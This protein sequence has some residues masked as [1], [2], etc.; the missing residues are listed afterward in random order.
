MKRSKKANIVPIQIMINKSHRNS[1]EKFY[2]QWNEW[3]THFEGYE[4][5][6]IFIWI[7]EN[8]NECKFIDAQ[9]RETR[10]CSITIPSHLCIT[11]TMQDV[12]RDLGLVLSRCHSRKCGFTHVDGGDADSTRDVLVAAETMAEVSSEAVV[13]EAIMKGASRKKRRNKMW[14]SVA[15]QAM[16]RCSTCLTQISA[17]DTLDIHQC[18]F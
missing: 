8:H 17:T 11:V 9:S 15:E 5:Q 18:D 2:A 10:N 12:Y 14:I 6:T 16:P 3:Q 7:V 13:S 4:L 1:E